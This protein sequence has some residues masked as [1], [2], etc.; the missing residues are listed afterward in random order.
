MVMQDTTPYAVPEIW[1]NTL[2][3]F[4]PGFYFLEGP[5]KKITEKECTRICP[6]LYNTQIKIAPSIDKGRILIRIL[7]TDS[8][9]KGL[10]MICMPSDSYGP[11]MRLDHKSGMYFHTE[12]KAI[13]HLEVV[14]AHVP[15]VTVRWHAYHY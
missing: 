11:D 12:H 5:Y 3:L 10:R 13:W 2:P 14:K 15:A 4:N 1:E 8:I 7:V 6:G 9:Y